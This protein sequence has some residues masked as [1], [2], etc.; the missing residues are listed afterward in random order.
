[1]SYWSA[2][3][4]RVLPALFVGVVGGLTGLLVGDWSTALFVGVPTAVTAVLL[5]VRQTP[6]QP[7]AGA[8]PA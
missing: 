7:P 8:P 6:E 3:A 2:A 4:R 5:P 1:V